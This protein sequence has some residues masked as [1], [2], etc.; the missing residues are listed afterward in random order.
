MDNKA[1]I[2][3]EKPSVATDIAKALGGFKKQG[4]YYESDKYVLSSAVGHLLE[5]CVPDQYEVKRGK[6]T[7]ANLPV[8]PPHFD[9]RPIERNEGRLKVLLKLIKRADVTAV[10]NACDA[11]REGELI[12]RNI[13]QY[14]KSSK[15]I[16][17]LWLQSMTPTA[18][19]EGF[20]RLRDDATMRPLADAAV[21][22]SESDWL[23]GING[24]RAMTAFNSKTGGFH[25]TTVGRVQTPTLAILVE[26]EE[27]IKNFVSKD[28]WE[29]HGTFGAKLGE[30]PGRWFDE[31]FARKEGEGDLK[32]E[33]IW[34][35][36]QAEAIRE[37]CLGRP[38]IVT[39]ES[40]PTTQ[41]S[42]LL[43]DLT[44]LQ[45]EANGRFGFSA[46]NTLA[47]AQSLYERHKVLTYPRTDS[48]ALPEDYLDTVKKTLGMLG[49]THY[50]GFADQ[51]LKSGWV[52]P[53]KRIFNN[54]KV[55]DHFAIIP[56]SMA[57]KNLSEPESKLYDMIT[58]RFLAVFYP[59][60]EFLVT[61]RITRVEGEPFKTEGKVMVS[62]GWLAVYGKEAQTD[63]TPTLAPVQPNETVKTINIEVQA[64]QTKP[65]PRF[66]EAT[67]L[68][69]MEGA[70]K[71]V[72]DEELR[73]AMRE[74]GLGT[75]ATRAQI[76]EGLIY[77]KYVLRQARDLQPTP[78]AF[79]LIAL[80]RGLQIPELSSPELTGNWEFKLHSMARGQMKRPDFM[81]EIADMTRSIV[82]KAKRHESD[83]V[84]GDF[85][86]LKVPCPKC[87]GEM[88]E[89]YKKF[90]CQK[91][92]FSL[93]KIVAGRQ[94]EIPEVEELITKRQVGPLQGFRSKMGRPFAAVIKLTPEL[95]PEF[96]FGQDKTDANGAA[97]EVDFTGQE[98]VGKCPKCGNSVFE[99]AMHYVCEKSTGSAR[100]C[101]FRSGKVILQQAV[102]RAQM[103]KLLQTGKTDL[104]PRFISKKGRPFKAYL[105]AKEGG[106]G[107]EFEPREAKTKSGAAKPKEPQEP[108]PKIDFKGLDP[109]GKCP[110]CGKRV[111]ES[112]DIYLC[113]Q[114]QAD[115]RPCKF[116]I[117]KAVLQQPIDRVQ[118]A[119]LLKENRTDLL[120]KF[121]SSKTGRSFSAYLVVD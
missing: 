68:S 20:E 67:L 82:A 78:K 40:K 94:L 38:G 31:K 41:L 56:T 97:A 90:Q 79:S 51:I 93:W 39:E 35:A 104:L 21:C 32:P 44:S 112:T 110:K 9:L 30:Y 74:K 69:A 23:V 86:T 81:Q 87:G 27:R 111:F 62:A 119:M 115:K 113:E 24:T 19:R 26:R 85:G 42:P 92:E 46:K 25:L 76:I 101:G 109:L 60:A 108:A 88:H 116:K 29:I 57:P 14:A 33:R 10:V 3:A 37:K 66:T 15:A 89:N 83:T 36:G 102:E 118:A 80:L 107:F 100:T 91:C 95:K 12:F 5:L 64:N 63:D 8:I 7:F 54:A 105:V 4:D 106:V 72:D 49:E 17:R 96:D 55:S 11:G 48:R 114:S 71:L 47:V 75:P 58:K 70:G 43:Y 45:R 1:L 16:Q 13:V 2:I 121:I 34:N 103:Q 73:E 98:P 59:A 120:P 6:W 65:P 18:I 52:R 53:N 117:S 61:T 77:E 99:T 50:S 28:Y 22:R 84:P